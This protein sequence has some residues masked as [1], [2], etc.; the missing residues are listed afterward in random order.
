MRFAV[1]AVLIDCLCQ[2]DVLWNEIVFPGSFLDRG[3]FTSPE[4]LSFFQ[5]SEALPFSSLIGIRNVNQISVQGFVP[6]TQ[7]P[8]LREVMKTAE[9]DA[10]LRR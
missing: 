3:H 5:A 10:C 2:R 1:L 6:N 4:R 8:I 7:I 9:S